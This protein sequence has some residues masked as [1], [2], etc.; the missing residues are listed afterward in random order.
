M[1][2]WNVIITS[3]VASVTS[4]AKALTHRDHCFL[5]TF[6]YF[7]KQTFVYCH[8]FTIFK[9]THSPGPLPLVLQW[10]TWPAPPLRTLFGTSWKLPSTFGIVSN[11][12]HS[13]DHRYRQSDGS[14]GFQT[15]QSWSWD[16]YLRSLLWTLLQSYSRHTWDLVVC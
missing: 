8:S 7:F 5:Y 2:I 11:H 10:W 12:G 3:A 16:R 4:V 14:Y 9:A 6:Y 13:Y 1:E 15:C